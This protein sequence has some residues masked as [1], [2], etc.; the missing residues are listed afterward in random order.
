VLLLVVTALFLLVPAY[1]QHSAENAGK[2]CHV[3][4]KVVDLLTGKPIPRVLVRLVQSRR[5]MLTGERGE[6]AFDDVPSGKLDIRFSK[7]GYFHDDQPRSDYGPNQPPL[8][9]IVGPGT[10][11][12][13]LKLLPE[14]FITGTIRG[15]DGKPL[16]GTAIQ[17][18]KAEMVENRRV[19]RTAHRD[20][21]ADDDGHFKIGGLAPGEYILRPPAWVGHAYYPL[22][23][24]T[25]LELAGGEHR[26]LDLTRQGKTPAPEQTAPP[27]PSG[28]G[29]FQ[30]SGVLV[31]SL[32]EQPIPGALVRISTAQ[33]NKTT[34]VTTNENGRFAFPALAPGKYVLWAQQRGYL[35]WQFDD[36]EGLSSAIAVGP[37]LASEDLVFR[38]PRECS[39]SGK[40]SD[41]AGEP[42]RNANVLLYRIGVRYGEGG[43]V[44]QQSRLTDE[45]GRYQFS[46]L[47]PGKY[48]VAV[49]S[50]VWYAQRP[51]RYQFGANVFFEGSYDS[52][53]IDIFPQN[54]DWSPLDVTYPVTFYPGGADASTAGS[55]VLRSGD[56]FVADIALQPVPAMHLHIAPRG[57][58]ESDRPYGRITL[59][60]RL[61]EGSAIDVP[62]ETFKLSTGDLEILGV[63]P[64][65]YEVSFLESNGTVKKTAELDAFSSGEGSL[66]HEISAV[67]VTATV[68]ID[69]GSQPPPQ[70]GVHLDNSKLRRSASGSTR[71]AGQIELSPLVEPGS[72]TLS[73]N[74]AGFE[75]VKAVTASG[76][77]VTGQTL[78]V[79]GSS[80]VNLHV[81]VAHDQGT[82]TGQAFRD[83]K[84]VAGA[85]V[86]LVP[87][88]PVHN[89]LLVKRDQSGSD[90]TFSLAQV[91]PGTYTLLAIEDGWD[92]EWRNPAVLEPYLSRGGTLVVVPKGKYQVRVPVQ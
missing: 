69:G 40:V 59:R 30:V 7:P 77:T 50:R 29:P 19:W 82:V 23:E 27:T 90:G 60:S 57:A 66:Q 28:A 53:I 44:L 64:G 24:A 37:G 75:Y 34:A 80:P 5:A 68:E 39:I 52:Q 58:G 73:T 31:D 55:I 84:P 35:T 65:H 49:A 12:L 32:N 25:P 14:A 33:R 22:S 86:L 76:G 9:V 3:G 79:D 26:D 56:R 20:I 42:V 8:R 83:G 18:V 11:P 85:M 88:D 72:Y 38:M 2:T 13:L 61:F 92:L 45:E 15:Q 6:F 78:E 46:R 1:A 89:P 36:H 41:E 71:V 43:T 51:G 81:T 54:Q 21:A 91:A 67:Q 62:A 47:S 70:E 16:A 10:S 87:P 74:G 63:A 4:G 48:F 17:V